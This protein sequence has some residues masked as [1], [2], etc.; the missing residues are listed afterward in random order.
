MAKKISAGSRAAD[1]DDRLAYF[2]RAGEFT[3]YLATAAGGALFLV[4]TEDKHIGRSLFAKQARGEF[5]VLNRAVGAIK[6][7]M[8]PEAITHRSFVDVGA[9][10]GTTTIAA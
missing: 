5:S 6:G 4:K 9:N 1:R 2:D 10:I 8:G 3:P 7:V